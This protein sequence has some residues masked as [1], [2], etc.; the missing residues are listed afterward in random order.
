MRLV[1]TFLLVKK[2]FLAVRSLAVYLAKINTSGGSMDQNADSLAGQACIY[3][4]AMKNPPPP[5]P[6]S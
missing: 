3:Y 5:Q 2:C 4:T 6:P 1:L